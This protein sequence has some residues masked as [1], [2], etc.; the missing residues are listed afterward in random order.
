MADA[1][2]PDAGGSSAK[3]RGRPILWLALPGLLLTSGFATTY[4]GLWSPMALLPDHGQEKPAE[5]VQAAE[6]V[7][8][9]QIVLTLPGARMRTLVMAVQIETDAAHRAGIQHLLPRLTDAFTSFLAEID[10][11]AFEKRGILEI[12]RDELSTRAIYVLGKQAFT[13][14]LITEFRIQ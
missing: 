1:A 12:V 4:L 3:G 2:L 13:D 7:A 11:S 6:F 14:I 9:P 5:P 8:V 10:P